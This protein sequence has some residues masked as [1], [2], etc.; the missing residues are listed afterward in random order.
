MD[1]LLVRD[2]VTWN[3]L[4][5][6]YTQNKQGDLALECFDRMRNEGLSPDLV[7]FTCIFNAC[8]STGSIDKGKSLHDEIVMI[9]G[10]LE[11]SVILG[12][13]LVDMYAKCCL[14]AKAQEVLIGLPIRDVISWNSV[15]VGYAQ[16]G[17]GEE[18]LNCFEE[19]QK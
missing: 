15:I 12:N 4:I 6:G 2:V 10:L 11:K 3:A 1:E 5:S 18:A 17:Q 7:T 14:L 8:G 9:G 19:M 13:A 16:Q